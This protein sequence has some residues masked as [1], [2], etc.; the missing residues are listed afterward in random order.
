[1]ISGALKRKT[2]LFYLAV[3]N[4]IVFNFGFHVHEKAILMTVVPL[5]LEVHQGSSTWTKLRFLVLKSVA[6][7]TLMPLLYQPKESLVKHMIL[8]L[9]IFL[10]LR[11]WLSLKVET[12]LHKV[13]LY[14]VM[15]MI[16]AIELWQWF[17]VEMVT[18]QKGGLMYTY[19]IIL[20][21]VS[22]GINQLI[23]L[24]MMF[25]AVIRPQSIEGSWPST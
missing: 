21:T 17:Y 16:V 24:E 25:R 18:D 4:F 13:I 15:T 20:P 8:F 6:V 9:D 2:F 11:V 19:R 7:F 1:M 22:S 10:T 12:F 5:G 14:F 23:F 3:C